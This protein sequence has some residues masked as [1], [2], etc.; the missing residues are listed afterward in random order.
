M[1]ML[2]PESRGVDDGDLVGLYDWPASPWLR[3]CMVIGLDGDAAG[4]DGLS[5]SLSSPADRQVLSAARARADAYLVGA[6]TVRAERYSPVRAHPL[7]AAARVGA[8][9]AVAPRLVVVSATCRFPWGEASFQGSDLSP[10]VLTTESSRAQDRAAASAAGCEV[11]VLGSVSVD[12]SEALSELHARGLH[13]VTAEGGPELLRQLVRADLVDEA[14]V[15]LS[16]TLVGSPRRGHGG[17]AVLRR[18]HVRHVLEHDG[19]LFTR[20]VRAEGV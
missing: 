15:T 16:P 6:A 20:Y 11:L 18:M 14:D 7:H 17:A 5:G 10:L 19:F 8:G 13:R 4:P 9:Q 1:R 12:L 2:L 3:A